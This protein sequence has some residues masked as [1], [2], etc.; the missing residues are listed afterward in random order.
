MATRIFPIA[1][2]VP[3]ADELLNAG[4]YGAGAVIRVQVGAAA[5]G[6]FADLSGTGAT[7]TL[8]LVSGTRLYTAF[9]PTGTPASWYQYRFENAGATRL[10]DY[11]AAFQAPAEDVGG[12]CS[13]YDAKQRLGFSTST[14]DA[15]I[16]GYIAQA[17]DFLQRET[18]RLFVRSPLSGT[19][20]F[21]YDVSRPSREL[22]I[23]RGIATVTQLEVKF[24][25]TS[26]F[27]TV[28]TADWFLD[29]SPVEPGWTYTHITLSD[30]PTGGV[31]YFFPGKAVVR[32]T[33]AEGWP[34]VPASV[35][36]A[37]LDFVEVLHRSRGNPGV[38][39]TFTVNVDGSRTYER[40]P[41]SVWG[42]IKAYG[43][44]A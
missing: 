33:G 37:G 12:V 4:L 7:A 34:A 9:D 3:N 13:L 14:E 24:T 32:M 29:P 26:S 35:E 44:P 8:P 30:L 1:I 31:P 27:V 43:P 25:T 5:A 23:P 42:V 17:T 11:V 36:N 18:G 16:L 6:P 39:A 20:T 2:T 38:G 10:S 21:L 15:N 28:P 19:T 40:L 22:W 41:A